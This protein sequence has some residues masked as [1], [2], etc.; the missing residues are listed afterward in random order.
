MHQCGSATTLNISEDAAERLPSLYVTL[1]YWAS[2]Q[3]SQGV[4]QASFGDGLVSKVSGTCTRLIRTIHHGPS[5][6]MLNIPGC[7]GRANHRNH[8]VTQRSPYRLMFVG[9]DARHCTKCA[10]APITI[11]GTSVVGDAAHAWYIRDNDKVRYSTALA[12]T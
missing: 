2:C 9:A 1:Q 6:T 12:L 10:R 4:I 7:Q 5:L 11:Y 3:W 8:T